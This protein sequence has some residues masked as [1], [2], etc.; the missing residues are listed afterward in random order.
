MLGRAESWERAV[1]EE[2]LTWPWK[3]YFEKNIS[4]DF[5][6]L[7]L[8]FPS[9]FPAP[10]NKSFTMGRWT[11]WNFPGVS[12]SSLIQSHETQTLPEGTAHLLHAP[13]CQSSSH[14]KRGCPHCCEQWA[15]AGI[16]AGIPSSSKD[17][18]GQHSIHL[19]PGVRTKDRAHPPRA[20]CKRELL[21]GCILQVLVGCSFVYFCVLSKLRSLSVIATVKASQKLCDVT[22]R[23]IKL[24][25]IISGRFYLLIISEHSCSYPV[26]VLHPLSGFLSCL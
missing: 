4:T 25:N 20:T 18:M 26:T 10:R 21:L 22:F 13:P 1:Q 12:V 9:F 3:L 17:G 19:V 11:F 23:Q 5:V 24:C 16:W 2:F 8:F 6:Y 14:W 7:C 15:W